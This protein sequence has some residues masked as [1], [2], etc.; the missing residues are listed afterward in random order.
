MTK[1]LLFVG[2]GA[3]LLFTMSV[4]T[5]AKDAPISAEQLRSELESAI[6]AK[7]T[8][9]IIS[10][11]N[12]RG[13]SEDMKSEAVE[14]AAEMVK[15]DIASVK[16]APLPADFQHTNELNGVRYFPN[17][18]VVGII[19]V[20]TTNPGN[21]TQI[22]YGE[23][24]GKF[25]L[26]GTI[27]ETFNANAPKEK[28]LG[29]MFIGLFPQKEIVNGRYVFSKG[30]KEI[31]EVVSFTNSISFIFW[32]DSIQSCRFTKSSNEGSM[33]LKIMEDGKNI[34]NSGMIKNTNA[35]SYEQTNY[36]L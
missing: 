7:D 1:K 2:V 36:V 35:V 34:F 5:F 17:V 22:P 31:N 19:D 27:K 30:G 4:T 3:L 13:V 33:R 12:L 24:D 23:K 9:A 6:K 21:G 29:I 14:A 18:A 8:N 20:E 10:L 26:P 16:L 25:F 28:S 11:F 15:D 32:G